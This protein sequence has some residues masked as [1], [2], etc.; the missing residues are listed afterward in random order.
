MNSNFRN[1]ALWGLIA[2]L[3]IALFQMFQSPESRQASDEIAYSRFTQDVEN[4]RVKSVTITGNRIQGSYT[5]SAQGFVT[6]APDDPELVKRLEAQNVEIVAR[7]PSDGRSSL[8]AMLIN[9]LP[10]LLLASPLFSAKLRLKP[11]FLTPSW[12]VLRA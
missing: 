6:Y 1:L 12:L 11:T 9:W 10:L 8:G 5:D 4:D 2:L 3:L 7:P